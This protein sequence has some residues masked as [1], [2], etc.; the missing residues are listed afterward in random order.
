M[1]SRERMVGKKDPFA[2]SDDSND[3]EAGIPQPLPSKG[4][5]RLAVQGREDPRNAAGGGRAAA[6]GGGKSPRPP[7]EKGTSANRRGG[8]VIVENP[9]YQRVK[10][11]MNHVLQMSDEEEERGVDGDGRV[12]RP[13]TTGS[14]EGSS[15]PGGSDK[16]AQVRQDHH[17]GGPDGA[18]HVRVGKGAAFRPREAGS[19]PRLEAAKGQGSHRP[20]GAA[21]GLSKTTKPPKM[22]DFSSS[23]SESGSD[24]E[25]R[26]KRGRRVVKKSQ[27]KVATA[28]RKV[29]RAASDADGSDSD[30]VSTPKPLDHLRD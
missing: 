6:G 3:G 18:P 2:L 8:S 4:G 7:E 21:G 27:R 14:S 16:H 11:K 28:K 10:Q 13:A 12:G 24:I 5:S 15:R 1:E 22:P 30:E 9:P 20:Q 26:G 29:R 19:G 23:G 25:L 17:G